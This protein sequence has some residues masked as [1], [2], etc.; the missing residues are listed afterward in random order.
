MV[1]LLADIAAESDRT[2]IFTGDA[3]VSHLRAEAT[4]PVTGQLPGRRWHLLRALG[5]GELRLGNFDAAR[6]VFEEAYA[7]V[8]A[9]VEQG[10]R[11]D[12]EQALFDLALAQL[13]WGEAQNCVAR[14]TSESCI[15][16]IRAGG[17]H[18]DQTGSRQAIALF[19]ELLTRNPED[20]RARWLLNLAYMT[21][22]GYPQDVPAP[23]LIPPERFASAEEFPRFTDVAPRLGL[24]TTD[25]AGGV[26]IDDFDSDGRLEVMTSTS[27]PSGPLRYFRREAGGAFVERGRAAGLEG[28]VGGM[29]L[30]QADYDNDGHTDVLVLRGAWLEQRGRH[31]KSLLRNN[32]DGTFTD[33]T[34]AAGL[35]DP[36]YPTQAAA[37][38]DYDN[39]GDLD[40]YVG[41]EWAS[42][43]EA[44]SQLFRNNGDGT[45]TDVAAQAG[46][47]DKR[48]AKGVVWA[49][50]D[51]DRFPDLY[52]SNLNGANRLYHNNRD[53]TFTDI[54][55]TAGV[56]EPSASI[57]TWAWDYDNDGAVDL[58]VASACP[59]HVPGV[60]TP[61]IVSEPRC[62]EPVVADYLGLPVNADRV[63]LY[64][65]DGHGG[66]R[67]VA[68]EMGIDRPVM[69]LGGNFG[70]LDHDGF[71][72]FYLGTGYPGYEAL[73]PNLMY[74]N[75]AGAGFA[76]ITTAG[77]FGHLQKGN[78][79]AFADLDDDG[80]EDVFLRAGGMFPGDR[81]S[82]V[83][84]ANPGSPNHWLGVHLVGT[85]SNRSAIGA[86]IRAEIA[87]GGR[88]R[89]IYRH[90]DSGG[91][92]GANPLRQMIG[93]GQATK[94]DALEIYWP[95]TDTVQT[96]HDVAAGRWIEVAEPAANDQ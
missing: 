90:V 77:G 88:R 78:A 40:L 52:V 80:D 60:L 20:L 22:G 71:L 11:K 34:F 63:H 75:R 47:E 68:P 36:S 95:T 61:G 92:F 38:A 67:D 45:F 4:A 37:W 49:D 76:D 50:V 62:L 43:V 33:V 9:L 8:P 56:T 39:D 1:V 12:A 14:H 85:R 21:I 93:L 41:N 27:D 5:Y 18:V 65:G 2:S 6:S 31:P 91:S 53:G 70:D 72:D 59:N 54:A 25:L 57:V 81:F 84:F 13:R 16:P 51:G 86:R 82:D 87:E 79:V 29:N 73:I 30:V 58:F 10:R 19:E 17:V 7:L 3:G 32:G 89:S 46:V 48:F 55:P 66:F 26:V 42:N 23:F 96:L 94:V 35:G 74:H 44:P 24:N 83:V 64:R 15:L 69:A 28:I